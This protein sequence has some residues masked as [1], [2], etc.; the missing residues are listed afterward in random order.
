MEE[1]QLRDYMDA[2]WY[3]EV[4]FAVAAASMKELINEHRRLGTDNTEAAKNARLILQRLNK[5][6]GR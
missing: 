2:L 6:L 5:E 1:W 4:D 3:C